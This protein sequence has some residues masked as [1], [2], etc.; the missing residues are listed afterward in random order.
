MENASLLQIMLFLGIIACSLKATLPWRA[1]DHFNT[2]EENAQFKRSVA[3]M[4]LAV[5]L[6][7]GLK[8]LLV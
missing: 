8:F 7:T 1:C 5:F 6:A 2:T 3:W 4:L